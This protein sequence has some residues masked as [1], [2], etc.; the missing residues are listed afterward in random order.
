[1]EKRQKIKREGGKVVGIMFTYVIFNNLFPVIIVI[2]IK[3]VCHLFA[4]SFRWEVLLLHTRSMVLRY[5]DSTDI[6]SSLNHIQLK[7]IYV[8]L[9][10]TV[11]FVF[12]RDVQGVLKILCSK[13][14]KEKKN[15]V[16][17]SFMFHVYMWRTKTY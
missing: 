4:V 12:V 15:V 8:G 3:G 11:G 5:E 10:L 7:L 1:M 6:I 13:K 17:W 9:P 16:F 2:L 14:L